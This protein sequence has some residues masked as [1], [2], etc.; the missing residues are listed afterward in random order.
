MRDRDEPKKTALQITNQFRSGGGMAYDLKCDGVRLALLITERTRADDPA[1][2]RIEARG[3]LTADR[4]VTVV[5]WG[6]TREDA[7]RA[8]GRSWASSTETTGLRVFDWDAVVATLRAV[9]A[10]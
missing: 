4:K 10:L 9:R 6:T 2:W 3:S 5:E 7:L 1:D 8:I